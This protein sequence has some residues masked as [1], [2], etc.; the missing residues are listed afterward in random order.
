MSDSVF[1]YSSLEIFPRS[2]ANKPERIVA[3]LARRATLLW[4]CC[5][6]SSESVA[7]FPPLALCRCRPRPFRHIQYPPLFVTSTRQPPR[8][9]SGTFS[10]NVPESL[11][12]LSICVISISGTSCDSGTFSGAPPA[13]MTCCAGAS[14]FPRPP[15]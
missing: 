4:Y 1:C 9:I 7:N 14:L 6:R 10:I 3:F 12:S 13:S 2:V 8:L 11:T 15:R 5:W